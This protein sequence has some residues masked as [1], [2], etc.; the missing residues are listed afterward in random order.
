MPGS[1]TY[2][3]RI[4]TRVDSES[5]QCTSQRPSTRSHTGGYYTNSITMGYEGP[6]TSGSAHGSWRS[7]QV[8]LDGQASD[9]VPVLSGVPQGSVL[10][11]IFF[12]NFH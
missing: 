4:R 9:S 8:D 6:P 7:Q 3:F 1:G 12:S 2:F 5:S 10:G 11:P